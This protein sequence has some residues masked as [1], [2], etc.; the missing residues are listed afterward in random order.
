MSGPSGR[1]VVDRTG[2]DGYYEVDLQYALDLGP[3]DANT[4]IDTPSL[5]TAVRE[6]LGLELR[7]STARVQALVI[8][9][10]DRPSEN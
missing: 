9:A 7:P 3:S 4:T 8:D 5:F 10:I 1:L 2:L 6:Q